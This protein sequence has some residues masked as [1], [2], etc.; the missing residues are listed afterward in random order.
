MGNV[1][2]KICCCKEEFTEKSQLIDN[3][4]FFSHPEPQH[5]LKRETG[6]CLCPSQR[7]IMWSIVMHSCPP[8]KP[9]P[10][11]TL[12]LKCDTASRSDLKGIG[13]GRES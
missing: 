6:L 10:Y 8:P 3:M 9:R 4:L 13:C 1:G 5:D 11:K 2:K 7:R 12:S